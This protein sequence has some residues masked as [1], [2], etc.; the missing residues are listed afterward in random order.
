[1]KTLLHV[2]K[3]DRDRL[4]REIGQAVEWLAGFGADPSGG[5]T[6]LLYDDAW[7]SAQQALAGKMEELGLAVRVDDCGNVVGR[8]PANAG[9]PTAER[10]V[11]LTGSHVDTVKSGGKFDGAYG[12]LAGM[13]ALSYLQERFGA[14]AVHLE[15]VSLCEEEGSRFPLTYWGSGNI[16]GRY[17]LDRIPDIRDENGISM[18][19]AME[20]AG[21]GKG[22]F[23]PPLRRD[24]LG[25]IELH[26]EQGSILERE[27]RTVGIVKSIVGQRRYTIQVSGSANHAGTTP[28]YL[29]Q[30]ALSG[31]CEMVQRLEEAAHS[32]GEQ[33]VATTGYMNVMPN[34]SNV[35]PEY[36]KFTV[37]VRDADAEV[38]ERFSIRFQEIFREIAERRQ[39]QIQVEEWMNVP[40]VPMSA[41]YNETLAQ[42]CDGYGFSYRFMNSG[43]GHDAQMLQGICPTTMLFVPSRGGI[44]HSPLEY[45]DS[46]DLANGIVALI[47]WLYFY[48]YQGGLL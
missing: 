11:L 46:R 26:I 3:S 35:I 14:P 24:L 19:E 18:G 7:M 48:G 9:S 44:S 47:E 33:F 41:S 40:P 32:E 27:R 17:D 23:A 28:M 29:R 20:N 36:V 37:D 22:A 5:V 43:A 1:M 38:L 8:L 42:I 25:F 16:T 15:V 4:T 30:D 45:S 39:L 12:I 31:A 10:G 6:R 21:Y 13:I 2:S 34:L